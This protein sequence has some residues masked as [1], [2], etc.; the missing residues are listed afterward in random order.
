[1]GHKVRRSMTDPSSS[2]HRALMTAVAELRIAATSLNGAVEALQAT[3]KRIENNSVSKEA[4]NALKEDVA[5]LQVET[6]GGIARN[7]AKWDKLLWFV[8]LGVLA[9]LIGVVLSQGG[10]P[11]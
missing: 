10:M 1:M 5:D 8:F 4:H 6:R 7:D 11:Q 3:V 9:A 2:E